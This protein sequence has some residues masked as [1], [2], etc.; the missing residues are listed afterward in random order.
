MKFVSSTD[1]GVP[2]LTARGL[3]GSPVLDDKVEVCAVLT[4][5]DVGLF[6]VYIGIVPSDLDKGRQ[7]GRVMGNGSKLSYLKAK[8]FFIDLKEEEY[9]R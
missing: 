2:D 3:L 9:R 5:D 7:R 8:A 1:W 6:A 4:R